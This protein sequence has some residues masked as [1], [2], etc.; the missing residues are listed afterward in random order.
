MAVRQLGANSGPSAACKAHVQDCSRARCVQSSAEDGQSYRP[1]T[2]MPKLRNPNRRAGGAYAAVPESPSAVG[3]N[4]HL[5]N[6][7]EDHDGP[8]Y[9]ALTESP[10]DQGGQLPTEPETQ[11]QEKLQEIAA[12]IDS[13]RP[14]HLAPQPEP[15]PEPQP[16][17]FERSS[18]SSEQKAVHGLSSLIKTPARRGSSRAAGSERLSHGSSQSSQ[19]SPRSSLRSPNQWAPAPLDEDD[20]LEESVEEE[21]TFDDS[22]TEYGSLSLA[23][24][25][26]IGNKKSYREVNKQATDVVDKILAHLDGLESAEKQHLHTTSRTE[27]IIVDMGTQTSPRDMRPFELDA[28]MCRFERVE[29]RLNST[30]SARRRW[31]ADLHEEGL[32]LIP[33]VEEV[34]ADFEAQWTKI[35]CEVGEEESRTVVFFFAL[36]GYRTLRAE[37]VPEKH[38]AREENATD[39]AQFELDYASAQATDKLEDAGELNRKSPWTK[40]LLSQAQGKGGS[41]RCVQYSIDFT[42][43]TYHFVLIFGD[44]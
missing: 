7:R 17:L 3:R 21:P 5:V 9:E 23:S 1:I 31:H 8:A 19:H 34:E 26:L 18:E 30:Q 40:A 37:N 22:P 28:D 39:E 20:G 24:R 42:L 41:T 4:S 29:R 27:T 43:H 14:K 11:D 10:G 16:Q 2:S 35:S 44:K 15:Q 32:A 38:S 25:K 33:W 6:E 13:G 36:R 12:E